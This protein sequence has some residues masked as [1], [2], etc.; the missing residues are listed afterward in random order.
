MDEE[1]SV[2]KP[3]H[4]SGNRRG[5]DLRF[6]WLLLDQTEDRDSLVTAER[7]YIEPTPDEG[8]EAEF[9]S[10]LL[11]AGVQPQRIVELMTAWTVVA[12]DRGLERADPEYWRAAAD[13]FLLRVGSPD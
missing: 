10:R 9:R 3:R 8:R 12:R 6:A 2:R 7:S 1:V 4:R 11:A 5:D 13:W